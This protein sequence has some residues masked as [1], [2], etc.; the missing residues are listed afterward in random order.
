MGSNNLNSVLNGGASPKVKVR[1][2]FSGRFRTQVNVNAGF[3]HMKK[4]E[5]L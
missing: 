1:A 5:F 3:S 2:L 4:E